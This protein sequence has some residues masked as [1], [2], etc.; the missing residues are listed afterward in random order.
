M[1]G[2]Y[3]VDLICHGTPSPL[4]LDKFFNEHGTSL[5]DIKTISFR[6]KAGFVYQGN[7]S[8]V[9]EGNVDSYTIAFHHS[10]SYTNNCYECQYAKKERISD[11][12]LG[13]A[14]GSS[15]PEFSSGKGISL[16]LCQTEK[17]VELMRMADI[18]TYDID[19]DIAIGHNAYPTSIFH[20]RFTDSRCIST[21]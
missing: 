5:S 11:V 7:Q 17:G 19:L 15:L 4:V 18:L 12:T 6:H 16:A 20:K 9:P 1:Y 21:R 3:T 2:L 10:Y 8:M 14:W 13:D